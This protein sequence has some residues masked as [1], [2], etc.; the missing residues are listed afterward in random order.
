MLSLKQ[1]DFSKSIRP[2]WVVCLW[3]QFSNL[4]ALSLSYQFPSLSLCHLVQLGIET[5]LLDELVMFALLDELTLIHDEDV[6]G[7]A[8]G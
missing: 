1:K 4:Y 5:G 2:I 7:M 8:H 3:S 6:V